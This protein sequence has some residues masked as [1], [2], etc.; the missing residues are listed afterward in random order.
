MIILLGLLSQKISLTGSLKV[1][2]TDVAALTGAG[3]VTILAR[4]GNPPA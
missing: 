3:E 2:I 1:T 4:Y